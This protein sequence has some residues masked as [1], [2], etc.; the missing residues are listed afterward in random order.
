MKKTSK[1]ILTLLIIILFSG[2]TPKTE[3]LTCEKEKED[4]GFNDN[5][6]IV[7]TYNDHEIINLNMITKLQMIEE[8][9]EDLSEIKEIFDSVYQD[10]SLNEGINIS[11]D[12]EEETITI[13]IDINYKNIK[14]EG[15]NRV[16]GTLVP[17][18]A[19]N[20]DYNIKEMKEKLEQNEYTCSIEV[21]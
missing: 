1:L 9:S 11:A 13:N 16:S 15:I 2:C 4:S 14:D 19:F 18:D 8:S 17:E 7:I 12:L 3:L 21:E 10:I 5:S 6:K 20:K